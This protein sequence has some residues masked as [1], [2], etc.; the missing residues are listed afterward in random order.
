MIIV[1]QDD[2]LDT[3][4]RPERRLDRIRLTTARRRLEPNDLVRRSR[5]QTRFRIDG[6]CSDVAFR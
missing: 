2:H 5:E 6:P 4:L 3:W 1:R